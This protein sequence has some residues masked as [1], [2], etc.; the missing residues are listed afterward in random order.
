MRDAPFGACESDRIRMY[1]VSYSI[2]MYK[3]SYG[4]EL[5]F[6][7]HPLGV[8]SG[9]CLAE[10][11]SRLIPARP[12]MLRPAMRPCRVYRASMRGLRPP[13]GS[14]REQRYPPPPHPP[15]L[16]FQPGLFFLILRFPWWKE[17]HV[18][19]RF[20]VWRLREVGVFFH[21]VSRRPV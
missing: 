14:R 17:A 19:D 5:V 13:I 21:V 16:W 3:V 6:G 11:T 8:R 2:R 4:N 12:C 18:R 9:G 1:K 7:T 10:W 15:S 20:M